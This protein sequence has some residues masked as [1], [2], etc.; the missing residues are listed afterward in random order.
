MTPDR[1]GL[2]NASVGGL[3]HS[4]SPE[5][6]GILQCGGK[7]SATPLCLQRESLGVLCARD[8]HIDGGKSGIA[9]SLAGAVQNAGLNDSRAQLVSPSP[10]HRI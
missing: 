3:A 4:P 2:G 5:V 1:P 10:C 7:R 9:A 6:G 8:V